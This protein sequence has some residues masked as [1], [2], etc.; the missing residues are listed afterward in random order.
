MASLKCLSGP[1]CVGE[2]SMCA[3]NVMTVPVIGTVM[4]IRPQ[5]NGLEISAN[6]HN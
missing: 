1:E 6:C 2:G 3:S 4:T 5:I